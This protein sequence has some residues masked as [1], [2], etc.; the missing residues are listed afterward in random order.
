MKRYLIY[1]CLA[2]CFL[3]LAWTGGP[4]HLIFP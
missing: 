2:L 1:V 3:C 4:G